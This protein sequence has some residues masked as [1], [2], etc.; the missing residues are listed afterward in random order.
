MIS[1]EDLGAVC[2]TNRGVTDLEAK[3]GGLSGAVPRDVV[4]FR[5]N[6]ANRRLLGL[7]VLASTRLF[8]SKENVRG[9]VSAPLA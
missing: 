1:F 4:L 6:L 8:F 3:R 5:R 2:Y 9:G 7:G